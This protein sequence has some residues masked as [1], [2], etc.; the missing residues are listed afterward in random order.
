[1]QHGGRASAV[2][3][4]DGARS[5]RG[6]LLLAG[7]VLAAV[8]AGAALMATR[9]GD[10]PPRPIAV[11]P[12]DSARSVSV[13][14]PP[15]AAAQPA[16]T[17]ATPAAPA[18]QP[19]AAPR[20]A[21]AAPRPRELTSA[22]SLSIA[23]AVQKRLDQTR[24]ER[25]V[26]DVPTMREL[27]QLRTTVHRQLSDSARRALA[28]AGRVIM[29]PDVRTMNERFRVRTEIGGPGGAAGASAG[30]AAASGG[31]GPTSTTSDPRIAALVARISAGV[32]EPAAG[33][34]RVAVMEFADATGRRDMRD[35]V[36]LA[37]AA[38]RRA[39]G[40]RRGYELADAGATR[41]ASRLIG[42]PEPVGE[43]T[44]S[45]AVVFGT[46]FVQRDSMVILAQLF[47]ARR[48]YP[49]KS[50][51]EKLPVD[52]DPATAL[53]AFAERTAAALDGVAWTGPPR[54]GQA[55]PLPPTAPK[56]PAPVP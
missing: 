25:G 2:P 1:V 35:A 41:D 5:R 15:P 52:S 46:V 30:A 14:V 31:S 55:R 3:P 33:V 40:E 32:A 18:P 21:P 49:F 42:A 47:D 56:P 27:E 39:V 29:V 43:A 26:G 45:G 8:T 36:R 4:A 37:S 51:T 9:G 24:R 23:E 19:A 50:V 54:R 53:Q 20:R 44:R 17:T 13:A 11:S 7:A 28:A 10:E 6:P 38:V 22:E 16:P 34:R 48:G 12:A